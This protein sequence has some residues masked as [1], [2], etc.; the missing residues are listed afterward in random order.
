[1]SRSTT[2]PKLRMK[3]FAEEWIPHSKQKEGIAWLLKH[4]EGGVFA[5]PGVGKTSIAL[6]ALK[7]LFKKKVAKKVLVIAPRRVC[8]RVWPAEVKKWHDFNHFKV[9]VLH[10]YNKDEALE[11]EADIYCINPEGLKWLFDKAKPGTKA[12]KKLGFDTLIVDELT[13]FKH[14]D[15]QRFKLLKG[16]LHTFDRRWGLTG[17]PAA[18]GLID[19]FGQMQI[20]DLGQSLGQYI[21][22]FRSKHF[23]P[24][25]YGWK[26]SKTGEQSIYKAISPY[27]LRVDSSHLDLPKVVERVIEIDLPPDAMKLYI[28]LE[29]NL[30]SDIE[31][32]RIIAANSAVASGKCRQ[33]TAGG[34]YLDEALIKPGKNKKVLKTDAGRLY[35]ETH[36]ERLE[37]FTDLVDELQHQPMLVGF[38]YGHSL[39]QAQSVYKDLPYIA[40]GTTDK[41]ADEICDAWNE[42]EIELLFG[43]PAAMGHGL[44]MQGGHC[45]HVCWYTP[46]WDYEYYDQFVRRVIR[47]GNKSD[48]VFIYHILARG[49][50]DEV[51][52]RGRSHKGKRQQSL[53]DA[54]KDLRKRR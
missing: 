51:V 46:T 14:T 17:T 1:M 6:G 5:D 41:R 19:L 25:G 31:E 23:M 30:L 53:F 37:A 28:E 15:S 26:P 24:T 3:Q 35:V 27:V 11:R 16:A 44:N 2:T 10:G 54:L 43:H 12:W 42:N 8:W 9:E 29:T 13:K 36:R 7:I 48:R 45:S 33:V 21:T 32:G 34:I 52:W 22:H 49:T 18:N 50:I 47:Q 38:E 20:I 4:P 40:G 39:A